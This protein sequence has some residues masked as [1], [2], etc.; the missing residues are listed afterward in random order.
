MA[1]LRQEGDYIDW[2]LSGMR[3][4]EDDSIELLPE[5][6]ICEEVRADLLTLG[7]RV[8]PYGSINVKNNSSN[9]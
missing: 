3:F 7:W 4:D 9:S 1:D 6:T 5:G 2:Y 8:E